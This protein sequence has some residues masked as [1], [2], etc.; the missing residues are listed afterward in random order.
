M[1]KATGLCLNEQ[2]Q[3]PLSLGESLCWSS[4]QVCFLESF[5]AERSLTMCQVLLK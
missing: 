5:I 4:G 1:M 3:A 2:I